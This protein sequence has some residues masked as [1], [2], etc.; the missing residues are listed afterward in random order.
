M[1]I[2]NDTVINVRVP[3]ALKKKF[4]IAIWFL[5]M[6]NVMQ[7]FMQN[8]VRDYERQYWVI[9]VTANKQEQYEMITNMFWVEIKKER[10]EELKKAYPKS[11][12]GVGIYGD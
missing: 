3:S 2:T 11:K 1:K 12:T 8:M 4:N 10:L 9:K 6:S 7:T 5:D